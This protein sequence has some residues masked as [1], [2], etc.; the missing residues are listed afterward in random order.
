MMR[1]LPFLC[2]VLAG[3]S[4][5]RASRVEVVDP[6]PTVAVPAGSFYMG[7]DPTRLA[8][9]GWNHAEEQPRHEVVIGRAFL[10]GRTEVTQE[11]YRQV[12]GSNPANSRAPDHPVEKVTW[13]Q[14]VAFANQ[15]SE[16]QGL[17][18]CYLIEGER[19]TWPRG[20]RCA[21]YRLPTEAEW[22]YAAKAGGRTAFSGSDRLEDV[23]WYER[24][25]GDKLHPVGQL[26]PNAWGLYDMSGNVW[27]WVWDWYDPSAYGA[28][29]APRKDP[30]GPEE[31]EHRVRRGGS[32]HYSDDFA[33]VAN[34]RHEWPNR[35]TSVLGLRL[36]RTAP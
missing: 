15:L 26:K 19:V 35:G 36:A 20:L 9:S 21:G 32:W 24:N 23:G 3:F 29:E 28:S 22:E 33:R 14:V 16:Q 6:F 17:E 34:R 13:L 18:P 30:T 12:T 10:L 5:C 4:G 1:A 2:S 7:S 8:R 27:E 25:S 11:L 31:G